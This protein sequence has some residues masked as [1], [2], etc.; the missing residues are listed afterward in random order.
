[1]SAYNSM[2]VV[3]AE[4]APYFFCDMVMIDREP[5]LKFRLMSTTDGAAMI[6]LL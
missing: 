3:S 4:E 1:M 5:N 2:V 6:L